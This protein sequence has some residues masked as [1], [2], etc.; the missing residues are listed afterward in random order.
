MRILY[1]IDTFRRGGK[2]RRLAELIKFLRSNY[3]QMHICLVVMYDVIDYPEIYETGIEVVILDKANHTEFQTFKDFL[4]FVKRFQ[5]D[6]VHSW[7]GLGSV[8]ASIAKIFNRFVFV[9]ALI[10]SAP[11]LKPISKI[12]FFARFSF[13]FSDIIVS[14][15]KAGL[16]AYRPPRAKSV[17]VHNGFNF[18]RLS[19]LRNAEDVKAEFNINTKFT[20]GM[21]ATFSDKK[22][23]GTYLKCAV[24]MISDRPDITFMCVGDGELLEKYM[25]MYNGEKR[26]IFTGERKDVESLVNI[27][28]IGVLCTYGESLSNSI[29]E[30]MSLSKPV[31]ATDRGGNKEIIEDGSSGF[32]YE[33]KNIKDL[34]Q[35]LLRLLDDEKLR[36]RMGYRSLEIVK[37]RFSIE[38]MSISTLELYKRLLK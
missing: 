8:Y 29:L 13:L 5:P 16:E 37:E 36:N 18:S 31:V 2:E 26:I 23:Y 38:S 17:I 34:K 21:V 3:E 12:W 30:Y 20:A 33:H 28:D 19:G 27:F 7:A 4:S 24:E 15:S 9:N 32:L 35:R 10:T 14:N 1:V 25:K 11:R 22:D 6:I